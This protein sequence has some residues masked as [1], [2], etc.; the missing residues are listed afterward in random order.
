MYELAEEVEELRRRSGGLLKRGEDEIESENRQRLAEIEI[1]ALEPLDAFLACVKEVR[2]RLEL[3]RRV[4][5]A[6]LLAGAD[7]VDLVTH[8]LESLERHH[9]FVVFR[10]I[11]DQHEDV[12]GHVVPLP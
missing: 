8:R 10:E 4:D 5:L 11:A 9:Y 6:R 7:S 2:R 3:E 1:E 12:F